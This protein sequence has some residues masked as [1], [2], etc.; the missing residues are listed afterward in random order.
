M[1]K[2]DPRR[3]KSFALRKESG[4]CCISDTFVF[5]QNRYVVI[6]KNTYEAKDPNSKTQNFAWKDDSS[7]FLVFAAQTS[8]TVLYSYYATLDAKLSTGSLFLLS[9]L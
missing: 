8:S 5:D 6:T 2:Y 1:V 3:A 4:S 9:T 7:I